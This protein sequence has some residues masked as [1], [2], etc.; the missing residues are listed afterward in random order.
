MPKISALPAATAGNLTGAVILPTTDKNT[1]TVGPTYAQ[2][3]TA[4]FGQGTGYATTDTLNIGTGGIGDSLAN[5]VL[6][7]SGA[8]SIATLT[9]QQVTAR[10]VGG[11]TASALRDSGNARNKFLWHPTMQFGDAATTTDAPVIFDFGALGAAAASIRVNGLTSGAAS[12]VG[13]LT[14]APASTNPNFW[15]PI[16]IAGAVRYFPCW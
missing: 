5:A 3:R 14:N 8:S 6:T 15:C 10:I 4:L 11:P 2:L 9:F 7:V 13:T 12:G 1:L 16:N